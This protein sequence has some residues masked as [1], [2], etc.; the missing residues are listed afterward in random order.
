MRR[1]GGKNNKNVR[2]RFTDGL[3][4]ISGYDRRRDP[5]KRH[6]GRHVFLLGYRRYGAAFNIG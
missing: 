5:V 4:D 6:A 1:V 2:P 3:P